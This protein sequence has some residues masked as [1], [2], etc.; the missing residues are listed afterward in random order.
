M[1][2][3]N[4]RKSSLPGI[5]WFL[6][7]DHGISAAYGAF[8]ADETEGAYRPFWLVGIVRLTSIGRVEA[9]IQFS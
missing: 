1:L 5:R 3:L 6:D 2:S 8:S 4:P 9:Q 7:Y